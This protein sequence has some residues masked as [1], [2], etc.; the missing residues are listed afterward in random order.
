M[1]FSWMNTEGEFQ[2]SPH[3][4]A[5]GIRV[6]Q[7]NLLTPKPTIA[8]NAPAAEKAVASHARANGEGDGHL[9]MY[10]SAEDMT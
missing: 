2:D 8:S 3:P 9:T 7:M 6:G 5:S 1:S 4:H 10:R